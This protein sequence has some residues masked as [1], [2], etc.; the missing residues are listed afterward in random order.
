MKLGL[1]LVHFSCVLIRNFI[2]K[3]IV[4]EVEE[5]YQLNYQYINQKNLQKSTTYYEL[6]QCDFLKTQLE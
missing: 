1:E 2:D 5:H 4:V 6:H 3:Y